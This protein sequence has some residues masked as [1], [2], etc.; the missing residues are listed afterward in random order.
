MQKSQ[1]TTTLYED[2]DQE[3]ALYRIHAIPSGFYP[4]F[5]HREALSLYRSAYAFRQTSTSPSTKGQYLHWKGPD[6]SRNRTNPG[7]VRPPSSPYGGW[8]GGLHNN[9]SRGIGG[10]GCTYLRKCQHSMQNRDHDCPVSSKPTTVLP[11]LN[12]DSSLCLYP[13]HLFHSP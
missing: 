11:T 6:Q 5:R 4:P 3:I 7:P 13:Y 2:H 1:T 8:Q 9:P 12:P 10:H